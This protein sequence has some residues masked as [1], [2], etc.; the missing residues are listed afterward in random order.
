[1]FAAKSSK[2]LAIS[3][4]RLVNRTGIRTLSTKAELAIRP[5]YLDAQATTPMDPRVLDAMMPYMTGISRA[6][7]IKLNDFKQ[8][9]D[10]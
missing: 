5:L 4:I 9:K 3:Y 6:Q 8:S 7:V 1:M 2:N 10:T